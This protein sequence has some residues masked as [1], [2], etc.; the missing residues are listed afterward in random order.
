M[1]VTFNKRFFNVLNVFLISFCFY[2][3]SLMISVSTKYLLLQSLPNSLFLL[4]FIYS[5]FN[6]DN[7]RTNTVYNKNGNK[8][9]IDVNSLVKKP[10]ER[11]TFYR[12]EI[13]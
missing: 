4:Y 10:I 11:K 9:L 1:L 8:M 6:V 7:Y 13:K 2:N 3:L 12:K 5:F